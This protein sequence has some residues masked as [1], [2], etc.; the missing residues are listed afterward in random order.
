MSDNDKRAAACVAL[1]LVQSHLDSPLASSH[2]L[3]TAWEEARHNWSQSG[4]CSELI[5]ILGAQAHI[6]NATKI[7]CF[8]LGNLEGSSSVH[9]LDGISSCDGLPHR[10][11]MT[12]HAAALTMA[13]VL[14]ERFGSGPLAV[15]AQDPAYTS[16][17]KPLLENAGIKV[18]DGYGSLAF[19]HVDA[20]TIVFSCHPNIPVKQIVAD[21]ARPAAM[22]WNRVK[23]AEEEK[24]EW[25]IREKDGYE[26]HVSYVHTSF[27]LLS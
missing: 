6:P 15:L 14:G 25:V 8:G 4:V 1:S 23:A 16:L 3:Q 11:A 26:L 27:C 13:T 24:S 9:G 21:I 19:T 18:V 5:A 20:N 2:K 10:G 12:Q 17:E 22:I 7:V